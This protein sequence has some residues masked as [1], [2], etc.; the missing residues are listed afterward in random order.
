M[1]SDATRVTIPQGHAH[2]G[3]HREQL[4]PLTVKNLR[5]SPVCWTT[6]S[7][8]TATSA[9]SG[10]QEARNLIPEARSPVA[11]PAIG[12]DEQGMNEAGRRIDT[13]EIPGLR[14]LKTLPLRPIGDPEAFLLGPRASDPRHRP[15]SPAAPAYE[16]G[17]AEIPLPVMLRMAQ[18]IRRPDRPQFIAPSDAL[19]CTNSIGCRIRWSCTGDDQPHRAFEPILGLLAAHDSG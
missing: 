8:V 3:V 16:A 4:P 15:E 17:G 19:Q 2:N 10:G 11:M 12:Q 1:R 18:D 13:S 7:A 6:S 5:D 14:R 9:G